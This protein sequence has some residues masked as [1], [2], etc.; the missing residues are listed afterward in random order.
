MHGLL[1]TALL[2]PK[3]T[4][5]CFNLPLL[6]GEGPRSVSNPVHLPLSTVRVSV[7]IHLHTMQSPSQ[8]FISHNNHIVIVSQVLTNSLLIQHWP[9]DKCPVSLANLVYGSHSQT[10][11][12]LDIKAIGWEGTL[13]KFFNDLKAEL[14]FLID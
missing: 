7:A 4:A 12:Q 9:N 3:V 13:T 1:A 8:H 10:Q 14:C 6:R 2:K 11:H 5:R